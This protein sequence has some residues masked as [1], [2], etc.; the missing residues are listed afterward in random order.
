MIQN[1]NYDR[2]RDENTGRWV[3]LS[4]NFHPKEGKKKGQK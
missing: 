2:I 4:R 3:N 1:E